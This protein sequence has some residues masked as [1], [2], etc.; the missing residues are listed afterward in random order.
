MCLIAF[1]W[2]PSG[3]K[4]RLALIANR[5]EFFERPT[6][7]LHWWNEDFLAGK[8]LREGGTWMGLTRSGRFAALTNYRGPQEKQTGLQSRGHIVA[9]FL[10]STANVGDVLHELE[11]TQQAYNGF[12]LICGDIKSGELWWL[13][14]RS[15]NGKVS[16]IAP[17]LHGLSNALLNTPW[18]K[19]ARAKAALQTALTQAHTTELLTQNL[20]A[21]LSD[22]HQARD[23]ALPRTGVALEWERALSSIYISPHA[24]NAANTPPY[25]TRSSSV[26]WVTQEHAHWAEQ[27]HTASGAQQEATS[28]SW[29]LPVK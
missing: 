17:G 14:N 28:F 23:E 27:T 8:D 25:G 13:S 29:H 6:A 9:N 18:P 16:R 7:P 24:M 5:D 26:L 1:D 21:T 10:R 15:E 12:N 22:S 11:R 3:D 4:H 20:L 19:V 2:Q